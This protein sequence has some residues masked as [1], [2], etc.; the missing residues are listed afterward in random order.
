MHLWT[1][2]GS[3][4]GAAP[5]PGYQSSVS[6]IDFGTYHVFHDV[7]LLHDPHWNAD[8]P[9]VH[10]SSLD[11]MVDHRMDCGGGMH[12]RGEGRMEVTHHD[13]V[14]RGGRRQGSPVVDNCFVCGEDVKGDGCRAGSYTTLS[15]N[16]SI[17]GGEDLTIAEQVFLK[18]WGT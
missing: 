17:K 13:W 10:E 7:L 1:R 3:W 5:H 4:V 15:V 9:V 2:Y 8:G 16:L 18:R 12:I 6:K 14:G 11:V